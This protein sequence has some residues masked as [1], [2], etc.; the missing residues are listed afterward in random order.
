MKQKLVILGFSALIALGVTSVVQ[1]LPD[2]THGFD[3]VYYSDDTFTTVVGEWYME[4]D[5]SPWHWGVRSQYVQAED[6]ACPPDSTGGGNLDCGSGFWIC[7]HVNEP[8][9]YRGCNCV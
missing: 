7:D 5:S 1:A 9:D 4:C 8:D 2:G 3:D 6:W